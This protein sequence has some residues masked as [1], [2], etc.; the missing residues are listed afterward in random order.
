M[1]VAIGLPTTIRGVERDQV[2]EWARRAEARGFSS[3]G[4]IDRLV[5]DNY[6]PLDRTGGGRG[7]HRAD[8]PRDHDPDRP[9]PRQRRAHRQ[10]GRQRR[11]PLERPARARGRRRR[12]RGRLHRVR[13]RLPRARQDLRRDAPAVARRVGGRVVR[14]SPAPIGPRP[15]RGRPTLIVGGSADV[16]F[17]RAARYGDGWI[18]GGGPPDQFARA[19]AEGPGGVGGGRPRGSAAPD[20]ARLL[21]ARRPRRAGRRTTICATTTPSPANTRA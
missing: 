1:E 10:A 9:V 8:P 15:P 18:M 13:R 7:G 19:R 3:L 6:E 21:R 4:T 5:Y 14:H 20:G 12:P 2:L 11:P 16:A 17:E